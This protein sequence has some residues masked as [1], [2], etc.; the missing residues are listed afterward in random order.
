MTF[1]NLAEF[2][3]PYEPQRLVKV[4]RHAYEIQANWKLVVENY[5]ECYHCTSIHPELCQ[6]TPPDSGE[7]I[8]PDGLW[9]GGTMVLKDH[10]NTMSLTGE[11]G[12]INFR[13]LPPGGTRRAVHGSLAEP[14]DQ[15]SSGLCDD[16]PDGPT[17]SGS[18]LHRMRLALPAGGARVG[19]LR[20]QLCRGVLGH[21]QPGGLDGL[22]NVQKGAANRG[23][24][25]GPLSPW[26]TTIYQFLHMVGQAYSGQKSRRH[27]CRPAQAGR[28]IGLSPDGSFWRGNG[29]CPHR[30]RQNG[31][32]A[33][34]GDPD[35][36][37]A[38]L[39]GDDHP[40][41]LGGTLPDPVDPEFTQNRSATFSR[42]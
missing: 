25:P 31:F 41:N 23:F 6:V 33:S 12:G 20:S 17:C 42:M 22:L 37:F 32:Y 16:P 5:H 9:C 38:E 3:A 8:A 15:P 13:N 18:H 11:S 35:A 1:G 19:G 21:H 36:S 34:A 24:R 28:S 40:L 39:V 2:L 27:R 26:E 30:A 10:A 7:D 4:A 29:A 14:I